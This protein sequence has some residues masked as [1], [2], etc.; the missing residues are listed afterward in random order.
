MLR[1][2]DL[3]DYIITRKDISG[4]SNVY[5]SDFIYDHRALH[6]SLTCNRVHPERKQ[7]DVRSPKRI[8]YDALEA[9]LTVHVTTDIVAVI[10]FLTIIMTPFP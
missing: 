2:S 7:I 4:V 3:L 8:T 5:V 1:Y 10:N 9:D 6:V